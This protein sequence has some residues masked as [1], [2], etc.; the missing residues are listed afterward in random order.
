MFAVSTWS[1]RKLRKGTMILLFMVLAVSVGAGGW[2]GVVG[3]G[4][5][6][7]FEM[8]QVRTRL[9]IDGTGVEVT[10]PWLGRLRRA[11]P[12]TACVSPRSG[13][14]S[15]ARLGLIG[16]SRGWGYVNGHGPVLALKLTDGREFLYSTRDAETAA[17]LVNGS[18]N[19]ARQ[20]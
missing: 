19:R 5:V 20:G 12:Y 1:W 10:L 8:L 13:P 17:A 3:L 18:L 6:A 14:E 4:L 16:G 2:Q 9:Q 15:G 11:V 7:V